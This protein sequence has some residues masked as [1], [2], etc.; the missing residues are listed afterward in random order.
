MRLPVS[1]RRSLKVAPCRCQFYSRWRRL[2]GVIESSAAVELIEMMLSELSRAGHL[3]GL[4]VAP[5]GAAVSELAPDFDGH[6]LSLLRESVGPSIP[7]VG[8]LD[9]HANLSRRMVDATDALIAYRTN[10]HVDQKETGATAARL[11]LR[12]LRG[13]IAPKMAMADPPVSVEIDCQATDETPASELVALADEMVTAPGILSNSVLLGF[14]YADVAELGSSFVVVA[15]GNLNSA[16]A[17]ADRMAGY[18]IAN[19]GPL[20]NRSAVPD[21]L[22]RCGCPIVWARLPAG[23]GR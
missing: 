8:T 11:L 7:I 14:P 22:A 17:Q 6:W 4:L 2:A 20:C 19:R 18:L 23:R 3:D 16:Q 12:T 15:D 1:S 13:Q 10:P 5:H 9:L 21:R